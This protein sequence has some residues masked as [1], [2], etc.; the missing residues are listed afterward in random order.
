[1]GD[2]KGKVRKKEEDHAHDNSE[3]DL[4]EDLNKF[5][6]IIQEKFPGIRITSGRRGGNP[7]SHHHKGN[8]IDIGVLKDTDKDALRM[9]NWLKNDPEGA[10]LLAESGLGVLD[11]TDPTILKKTGGSAQHF[12]IGKDTKYVKE[13]QD[14]YKQFDS[15]YTYSGREGAKYKKQDGKW[16]INLGEQTKNQFTPIQDPDGSRTK[17][18]DQNATNTIIRPNKESSYYEKQLAGE[19]EKYI[20]PSSNGGSG[21]NSVVYNEDYEGFELQ[22]PMFNFLVDVAKESTKEE[23]AEKKKEESSARKRLE[24]AVKEKAQKRKRLLD[25][26]A[27]NKPHETKPR[28]HKSQQMPTEEVQ[29]IKLQS[30]YKLPSLPSISNMPQFIEGEY[31]KFR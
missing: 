17:T 19:V 31:P 3:W 15:Y 30:Q 7:D 16:L 10:R 29:D 12:H 14:R 23:L 2:D 27:S 13:A 24:M 26:I 28:S 8:A 4:S 21:S 25:A 1:M 9:Y 18:L 11:E 6:H 22:D 5:L 20:N